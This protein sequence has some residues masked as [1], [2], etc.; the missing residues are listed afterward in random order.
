VCFGIAAIA[1]R[2]VAHA[3]N[4]TYLYL[5]QHATSIGSNI[6]IIIIAISQDKFIE[7]GQAAP[8][9]IKIKC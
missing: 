2:L 8:G 1:E 5:L 7:L 3:K 6:V 4:A 9:A